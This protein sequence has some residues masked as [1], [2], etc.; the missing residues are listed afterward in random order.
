MDIDH[1]EEEAG[2]VHVDVADQPTVVDITHDTL[3]R[4]K[5]VIDM[6]GVVHRQNDARHDHDDQC[7]PGKNTEIPEVVQVL[8]DRVIIFFMVQHREDGKTMIDPPDDG[9]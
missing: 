5:R 7:K 9:I 6:R 1:D 3:D 4:A 2:R 8:R